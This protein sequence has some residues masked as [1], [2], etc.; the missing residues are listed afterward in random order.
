MWYFEEWSVLSARR[1]IHH[2]RPQGV[3][4]IP[5]GRIS[6]T[7]TY[8]KGLLSITAKQTTGA[9]IRNSGMA[10]RLRITVPTAPISRPKISTFLNPWKSSWLASDLQHM[11]ASSKLQSPKMDFVYAR[12]RFCLGERVRQM[13][14]C[15]WCLRGDLMWS[16]CWPC[17]VMYT[18]KPD[19]SSRHQ[20]VAWCFETPITSHCV[21]VPTE[22]PFNPFRP[23]SCCGIHAWIEWPQEIVRESVP[24]DISCRSHGSKTVNYG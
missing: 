20:T 14:K 24:H 2:S 1:I 6:Q 4:Q 13:L 22:D 9:V 21:S 23:V 5:V 3:L 7:W 19:W 11:P 8:A 18:S 12:I 15:Q 10:G 16:I 17:S